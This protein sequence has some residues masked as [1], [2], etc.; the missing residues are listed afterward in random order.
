MTTHDEFE[1][2]LGGGGGQLAHAEVVDD[3][4][5][6]AGERIELLAPGALKIGLRQ[7]LEQ[8]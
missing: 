8:M 5:R 1:Q 7:L 4:Q 3:D 2:V 6:G